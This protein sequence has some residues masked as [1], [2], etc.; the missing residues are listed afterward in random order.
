MAIFNSYVKLPEGINQPFG[1]PKYSLLT[2]QLAPAAQNSQAVR[3]ETPHLEEGVRARS[4]RKF[5]RF[6]VSIYIYIYI[7]VCIYICIYMYICVCIILK[8]KNILLY[9]IIY[10][11]IYTII[12]GLQIIYIYISHQNPLDNHL[13]ST[14]YTE[15]NMKQ[16]Y[17]CDLHSFHYGESFHMASWLPQV[18]CIFTGICSVSV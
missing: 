14:Q 16:S 2:S 13:C 4:Q 15:K 6:T 7:Y 3:A 8:Y 11:D 5:G 18:P 17:S 12:Y 1:K 9:M 10:S